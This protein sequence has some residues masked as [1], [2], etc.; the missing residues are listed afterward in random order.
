MCLHGMFV[1]RGSALELTGRSKIQY[2]S[3]PE[4]TVRV[5]GR[6]FIL[7]KS[8]LCY[9]STFFDR[10]F[11]G[12][13]KEGV[14]QE[15]TL[16]S[17]SVEAFEMVVQWM[18]TSNAVIPKPRLEPQPQPQPQ[19]DG[20]RTII[21]FEYLNDGDTYYDPDE[22]SSNDKSDVKVNSQNI[23][24][25][26][27]FLKLADELD[28]LGPFDDILSNI[29]EI[30]ISSQLSL[31][32]EHIRGA[33]ELPSGHGLR[34]LFAQACVKRYINDTIRDSKSF[35]FATEMDEVESFAADLFKEVDKVLRQR[36]KMAKTRPEY[37]YFDPLTGERFM[38]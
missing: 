24:S 12:P 14:E 34:K 4:V 13:W 23:I 17:A 7:P 9:N 2:F 11:N 30:L 10:A 8:L 25:Y 16:S 32:P 31:Q 37:S 20:Q 38:D 29:K 19:S 35:R 3:G 33:S 26:L 36:H 15:I 6:D 28:L 5:C 18:Y 1:C 21:D 27:G 22:S